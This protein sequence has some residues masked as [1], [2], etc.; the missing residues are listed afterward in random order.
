MSY[1]KGHGQAYEKYEV[2]DESGCVVIVRPD[3]YVGWV[4][5]VEEVNE[6]DAYFSAILIPQGIES[7]IGS[8]KL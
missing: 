1:H 7:H 4:G 6:I 8:S 3:Q 5:Q 2:D